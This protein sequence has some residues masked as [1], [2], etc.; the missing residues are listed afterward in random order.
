ML[1]PRRCLVSHWGTTCWTLW[2]Q[3]SP[4]LTTGGMF[5][6]LQVQPSSHLGPVPSEVVGFRGSLGPHFVIIGITFDHGLTLSI[7]LTIHIFFWYWDKELLLEPSSCIWV[8]MRDTY[9]EFFGPMFAALFFLLALFEIE[10]LPQTLTH[11]VYS[12]LIATR[13]EV[14]GCLMLYSIYLP[15]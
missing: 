2:P 9:L 14:P 13:Q 15:D 11:W 3:S 1:W 6:H 8:S 10:V 12:R 7:S 4:V 5:H